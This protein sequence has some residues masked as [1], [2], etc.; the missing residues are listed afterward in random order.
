M[1]MANPH[2]FQN[3]DAVAPPLDLLSLTSEP[4]T[5]HNNN[6]NNNG[7]LHVR[8]CAAEDIEP[9]LKL[10]CLVVECQSQQQ[11]DLINGPH[12]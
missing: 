1:W 3:D 9:F 10:T 4:A 5:S 12:K 6:N 7:S 11:F 8:V 2:T